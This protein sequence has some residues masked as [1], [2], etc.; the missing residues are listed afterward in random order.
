MTDTLAASA[1]TDDQRAEENAPP[2]PRWSLRRKIAWMIGLFAGAEAAAT[3]A[4]LFGDW[5]ITGAAGDHAL[6]YGSLVLLT[7]LFA[8]TTLLAGWL[9]MGDGAWLWRAAFLLGGTALTYGSLML[10]ELWELAIG[11]LVI[12]VLHAAMVAIPFA[13]LRL[14]GWACRREPIPSGVHRWQFSLKQIMALTVLVAILVRLS[15]MLP[16]QQVLDSGELPLLGGLLMAFSIPAWVAWLA[17]L[18]LEPRSAYL[19]TLLSSVPFAMLF[20]RHA[21]YGHIFWS[22]PVLQ[23]L[24]IAACISVLRS[25][26]YRFT[27]K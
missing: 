16:W 19:L 4:V 2:V 13:I 25:S 22:M 14:F 5:A 18:R 27:R 10:T 21:D 8:Q 9:A 1:A 23:C 11:L 7:L 17:V 20:F 15:M 24:V 3:V 26:G 12:A 6:I